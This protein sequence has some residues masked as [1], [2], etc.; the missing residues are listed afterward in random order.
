MNILDEYT[1][2]YSEDML[3]RD[4]VLPAQSSV[5]CMRYIPE[6]QKIAVIVNNSSFIRILD[7]TFNLHVEIRPHLIQDPNIASKDIVNI[8]NEK[9]ARDHHDKVVIYDVV[10]LSGKEMYAFCS[11]DCSISVCKEHSSCSGRKIHFNIYSKFYHQNMHLKLCWSMASKLLC[12][13][14]SDRTIYGNFIN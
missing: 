14:A 9:L 2:E 11:S 10:Y 4:K 8:A 5:S 13:V 12:S 6:T 7:D 1:I 3:M